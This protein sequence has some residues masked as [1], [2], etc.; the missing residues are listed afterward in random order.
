MHVLFRVRD[1]LY[2]IK[3]TPQ[4]L[5]LHSIRLA[6]QTVLLSGVKNFKAAFNSLCAFASVNHLHWHL[7]YLQNQELKLE[8]IGAKRISSLSDCYEVSEKDYPAPCY[9]FQIQVFL[10][11][12]NCLPKLS[13]LFNTN[14]CMF[15]HPGDINRVSES[16]HKLT[17]F[18]TKSN[19]AHNVFMTRGR[20]FNNSENE[21]IEV[22]R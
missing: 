22:L 4:V 5:T 6:I 14:T 7:Y 2:S 10:H 15:Q 12:S 8:K 1:A 16:V 21:G 18:L 9:A 20:N 11:S 13:I 17:R 3:T 19:T